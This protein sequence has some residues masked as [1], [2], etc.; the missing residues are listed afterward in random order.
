M[1]FRQYAIRWILNSLPKRTKYRTFYY[2]F[3]E[4]V[5]NYYIDDV[6]LDS[7]MEKLE[8]MVTSWREYKKSITS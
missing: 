1:T 8:K 6:D 2:D 7:L 4:L 5:G 3:A